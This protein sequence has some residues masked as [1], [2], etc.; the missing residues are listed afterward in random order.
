MDEQQPPHRH[1]RDRSQLG[2]AL[3]SL[4]DI[5]IEKGKHFIDAFSGFVLVFWRG[6]G[7]LPVLLTF[8]NGLVIL[9]FSRRS[10]IYR[11]A[12]IH[13]FQLLMDTLNQ[14]ALLTS[15][16]SEMNGFVIGF[17]GFLDLS[18]MNKAFCHVDF[19]VKGLATTGLGCLDLGRS[20]EVVDVSDDLKRTQLCFLDELIRVG[21]LSLRPAV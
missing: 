1:N 6:R 20:E 19:I 11:L 13:L 17:L 15:M 5:A 3:Q 8:R 18:G 16:P 7:R 14:L 12:A 4:D 9:I 10:L 2:S 21:I